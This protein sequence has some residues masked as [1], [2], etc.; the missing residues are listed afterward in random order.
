MRNKI[1][2]A[3][4]AGFLAFTFPV[5][6][7]MGTQTGSIYGKVI[8]D[9]GAPLPGVSITLESDVIPSQTASSG[10]SG[11]FRFANLP[12]GNY[13]VNFSIEGFTE[14][15]QEAVRVGTGTQVQL[16]ITLKPS[17]SE[18]FTVIG[19]TPVVDTA[20]TGTSDNFS[21]E[22]LDDVPSAR[23]PWVII[24]QTTGIQSDRYNVAGSESGQQAGFIAR[25][26]NDDSTVWNYDGVNMSDPGALGASPTYFDFDSFEEMAISTGG[27]DVSIPTGGVAVNIVTKRAGNKWEGDGSFYFVN[28]DLQADNTPA[29]LSAIGAKSNRLNEVKDYGFDIGGPIVKDKFFAWGAYH[30]NDISLITTANTIDNTLLTDYNFKANMNW[31]SANESQFGYFEGDKEK[32]GRAAI[33]VQ[34]Q[35]PETLWNQG[36][37]NTILPGLWTFQHTWIPNDHTIVTGRYGYIG[38]G[39]T[40]IPEG[41]AD[42]PMIY[43]YGIPRW[44]DSMYNLPVI[45]RPAH[46]FVADA[47]YFKENWMG[48]D[49]EFKFGFEYKTAQ[50]HTISTY[51]NGQL[52]VDYY[53]TTPGGPLTSGY[54]KA[55][56]FVDGTVEV[57]RTSFYASDTFRKDKLTLNLGV[58]FDQQTGSNLPSSIPAVPGFEAQVPEFL[59]DGNNPEVTFNNF[60]PRL[61][62]TYDLTGDGKTII[63]GNYARYYD[64]YGAGYLSPWN[65]GFTYNGAVFTYTNLNN[66]RTVQPN[67]VTGG[68]NYYGGLTSDGS[69]N[70]DEFLSQNL[71]DPDLSNT[72]TDEIIAGFERQLQQDIS[73]SVNYTYRSYQNFTTINPFGID[74]GDYVFN[75]NLTFN[76]ALG[77]FTVPTFH[78][79]FSQDGTNILTNIQ[80]YNQSYN[81]VDL[82]LRKRMSNDF[83][84]NTGVT[85]QRQ[86]SHYDS[87]AGLAFQTNDAGLS[88]TTFPFDPTNLPYMDGQPYSFAPAGSGKSGVYPYAEWI[89]K[90]SGV[91]Q[92]KY[93]ISVGGYLRYQQGYPY[94][95][96]GSFRDTTLFASLGTS[97]HRVMVEP[98]GSRRYD[99]ILGLD[100]Q[101]EKGLDFGQYGR[102]ALSANFFNVTNSNTVLRRNRGVTAAT[103]NA[104]DEIISPFAV[105]VGA[106]YSF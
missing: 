20:K 25:G 26:G 90:L 42:V 97:T 45:D 30:K 16:E 102:L 44:E 24:D 66:D 93:D 36:G 105:R 34:V 5:Y 96:F 49:H 19:E 7:Q 41:G 55:Q 73:V 51:G 79:P 67:E 11:G 89:F 43:L 80:D 40:L 12:P 72:T 69:F 86:S 56:H 94:V 92:F 101:V 37:T 14:V 82:S 88:G 57:N 76:T 46:D 1:L 81:G 52:I 17:L 70:L 8:D 53:Q 87:P 23:D 21:R 6:A 3:L 65:P 13:S 54:V 59:F 77:S 78:L 83:M 33:S 10:P 71:Y 31:N 84:I 38:L 48:G 62:A 99:N 68:P 9:K 100:L 32:T 95:L 75:G 106:R 29:E 104:I 15:R 47:N 85:L 61:G 91:Y 39:F 2:L 4:V 35:A 63:R 74:A 28:S 64:P 18:E 60:S 58:R 27:N 98:F 103:F 22:Y 50:V